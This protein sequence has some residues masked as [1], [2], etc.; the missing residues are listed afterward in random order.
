MQHGFVF[1]RGVWVAPWLAENG[2]LIVV[3]VDRHKRQV[4]PQSVVP[5]G[6]NHL[7]TGEELW[8]RLDGHDPIPNLKLV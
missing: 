1:R 5:F 2:G 8:D 7:M 6:G 3:A 4:G